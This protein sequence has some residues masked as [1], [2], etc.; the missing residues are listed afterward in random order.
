M[1]NSII[2]MG[3][4]GQ[5]QNHTFCPIK[6]GLRKFA[7]LFYYIKIVT[8]GVQSHRLRA[9]D[10]CPNPASKDEHSCYSANVHFPRKP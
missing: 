3:K 4:Q 10:Q 5:F 8:Y 9:L 2:R 1:T 7:D 6:K